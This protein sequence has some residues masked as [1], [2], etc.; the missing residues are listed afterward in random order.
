MSAD[1]LLKFVD[2]KADYIRRLGENVSTYEV[3]QVIVKFSAVV[4]AAVHAV[5]S[6]LAEGDI[7]VCLILHSDHT[8]DRVERP[9]VG[10]LRHERAS[11]TSIAI[12][13]RVKSVRWSNA[14]NGS[15]DAHSSCN[16]TVISRGA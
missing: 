13:P 7:K 15:T 11:T 2:R 16:D 8:F 14:P 1:G 5:P 4:E 6:E 10:P 3:E 12:R 9:R